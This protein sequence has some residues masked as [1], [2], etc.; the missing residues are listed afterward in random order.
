MTL[1]QNIQRLSRTPPFDLLP[2]DA[3]QLIA[4]AAEQ[5]KLAADEQLFEEGEPAD[6]GFVVLSGA[7][8]LSAGGQ[9]RERRRV[10]G[11]GALI[12]ENAMIAEVSRRS[13]A[14]ATENSVVLRVPRAIFHRVLAEFPKD[15]ARI[16]ASLAARTRKM[17]EQL[18]RLRVTAINPAQ[19]DGRPPATAPRP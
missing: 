19:Q 14:R 2:R 9:G 17:S 6:S 10:A 8:L 18:E 4:F 5:R 12:G 11:P 1:E 7:I 3:L 15:A 16:R 13:S